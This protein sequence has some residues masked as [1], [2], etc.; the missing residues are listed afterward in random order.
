MRLVGLIPWHARG[1]GVI[2]WFEGA[3]PTENMAEVVGLISIMQEQ[4]S[5][6]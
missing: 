5:R 6:T 1:S 2:G 4:D 3:K